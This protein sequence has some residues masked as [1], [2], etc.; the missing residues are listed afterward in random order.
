MSTGR[1]GA[2]S[3]KL[4]RRP[5]RARRHL[6]ARPRSAALAGVANG[7]GRPNLVALKCPH[8]LRWHNYRAP[9]V[10]VVWQSLPFVGQKKRERET[11]GQKE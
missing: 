8:C 4:S 1:S 6:A 2:A 11:E 5:R 10:L 3:A 9:L 7:P